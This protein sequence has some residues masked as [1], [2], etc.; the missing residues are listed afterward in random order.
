MIRLSVVIATYNRGAQLLRTLHSLLRQ[1]LPA[2]DWEAVV[3]NNCSTDDTAD[4]VKG[5]IAEHPG[6]HFRL[7]EEG[8]QGLSYARNRGIAESR[9]DYIVFID[10]DVELNDGFAAAYYD[11]FEAHPDAMAAGGRVS[12]LYET[13]RPEWMSRYT[14]RPIAGTL[15]KGIRTKPFGRGYPTGCNMAFRAS[16]F[17]RIGLFDTE[18]GRTGS[19]P[20]GGEEKE[21]FGRLRKTG[22]K[23]WYVPGAM[24]RHIIPASKLTDDY[25]TRLTCKCGASE[26][27]RTLGRSQVG[28]WVALAVEGMKWVATLLIACAY[29]LTG[30]KA[31]ACRLVEMRRNITRGLLG[32]A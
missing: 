6:L 29:R 14:E 12:P 22:D 30:K 24:T 21:F 13:E 31:R 16:V 10:D 26:R 9:G 3:V 15:D 32:K 18:L 7:V 5:F 20:L 1:T 25:F 8:R 17:V 28:Y 23:V 19:N 27:I 2:R 11:F 4:I